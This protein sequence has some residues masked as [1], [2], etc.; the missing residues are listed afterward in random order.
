M[1][2]TRFTLGLLL[3]A[4][5]ALPAFALGSNAGLGSASGRGWDIEVTDD[6]EYAH[7]VIAISDHADGEAQGQLV[8]LYPRTG[9]RMATI[10]TSGDP[11]AVRR[12]SAQQ[13]LV[14][15]RPRSDDRGL[16]ESRL[17]V[18]DLSEGVELVRETAIPNRGSYKFYWPGFVGLSGDE[19]T[20]FYF[21]H[22]ADES[23][24]EHRQWHHLDLAR[25]DSEP[26]PVEGVH[27][28][29]IHITPGPGNTAIVDCAGLVRV[30]GEGEV[31][32]RVSVSGSGVPF[33]GADG[34]LGAIW[35]DGEVEVVTG[36]GRRDGHIFPP[37][38]LQLLS[39]AVTDS[40][41]ILVGYRSTTGSMLHGFVEFDPATWE[42]RHAGID[43]LDIAPGVGADS[44]WV[45]RADGTIAE[46]EW[47][48]PAGGLRPLGNEPLFPP[49]IEGSDDFEWQN[50]A[51][52]P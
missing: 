7:F 39:H 32:E 22:W 5:V 47:S 8:L 44:V 38:S 52:I 19:G 13:L 4:G 12:P 6:Y 45:L 42:T 20:F 17:L 9:E 40:G 48:G 46:F 31:L 43:A 14:A 35:G 16:A 49:R 28:C 15:D 25:P 21:R 26:R 1:S 24:R 18:F 50:W 27:G 41:R 23:R 36:E 29:N 30:S 33:A 2:W 37:N 10:Y 11:M 51:L 3:L 34:A